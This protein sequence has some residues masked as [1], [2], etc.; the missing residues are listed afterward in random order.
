MAPS[1]WCCRGEGWQLDPSHKARFDHVGT[2]GQRPSRGPSASL[3]ELTNKSKYGTCTLRVEESL[4]SKSMKI[5]ISEIK[6]MAK[7]NAAKIGT[8]T[9]G[10]DAEV[11]SKRWY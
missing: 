9:R 1:S 7:D 5:R 10:Q 3:G 11:Q 2:L 4:I 6:K 8:G